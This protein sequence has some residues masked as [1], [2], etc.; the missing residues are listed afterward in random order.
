VSHRL[1]RRYWWVRKDLN[2]QCLRRLVYSQVQ[3]R[4][5]THPFISA[6]GIHRFHDTFRPSSGYCFGQMQT[7]KPSAIHHLPSAKIWHSNCQSTHH[8]LSLTG[9]GIWH[10]SRTRF[11]YTC[12]WV[13]RRESHPSFWGHNPASCLLDD[14]EHKKVGLV[15]SAKPTKNW[16]TWD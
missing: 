13:H 1:E 4:S 5:A 3:Y 14:N 16:F 8:N 12:L 11:L 10:V 6:R 9:H 2:L 15:Y 7:A